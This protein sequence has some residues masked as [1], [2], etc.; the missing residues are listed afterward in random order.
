MRLTVEGFENGGKIPVAFTCDG[1]DKSPAIKWEELPEGTMSLALALD[2]P[3]APMGT[4]THWIVYNIKPEMKGLEG[5]LPQEEKVGTGVCQGANDFGTIGYK[6]PCPPP[7]KAHTYIFH[8]YAR[9]GSETIKPAM[10]RTTLI[11]GYR[12]DV[13]GEATYTGVYGRS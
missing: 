3:D 4:F 13:I 7:G 11:R 12:S 9:N 6:G 5:A 2:D 1:E 8:L 10:G